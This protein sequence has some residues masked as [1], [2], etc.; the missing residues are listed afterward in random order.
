MHLLHF[1]A[2]WLFPGAVCG[3]AVKMAKA[4]TMIAEALEPDNASSLA[5]AAPGGCSVASAAAPARA[6]PR[7]MTMRPRPRHGKQGRR[8]GG[9]KSAQDFEAAEEGEEPQG[10]ATVSQQVRR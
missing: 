1:V 3:A 5:R 9:E 7:S 8:R 4:T 6:R 10:V 2:A